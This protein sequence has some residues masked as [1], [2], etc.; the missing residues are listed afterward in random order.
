MSDQQQ[1]TQAEVIAALV[2]AC[3]A[4]IC[5]VDD[6]KVYVQ[7]SDALSLAARSATVPEVFP[8]Y[9]IARDKTPGRQ[10]IEFLDANASC[11]YLSQD[12]RKPKDFL[13]LG[14]NW[15]VPLRFNRGQVSGLIARL[16]CWLDTG[17]FDHFIS[18]K[19]S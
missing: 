11:G 17:S 15:R 9:G 8:E 18:G 14:L 5:Q 19:E 6:A 1:P 16:Q 3:E 7:L 10:W 2:A 4:A 13:H 12:K